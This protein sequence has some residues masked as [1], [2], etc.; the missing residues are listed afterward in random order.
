MKLP[1]GDRAVVEIEKLRDYSLDPVH[2]DGKHKARV[3]AAALGIGRSQ[4]E[5]LRDEVLRFAQTAECELGR[6]TDFGQRYVMQTALSYRNRTTR[7]RVVWNIRPDE[8]FP[9]MITC[10][11]V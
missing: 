7:V 11:V 6:K 5:W 9:R 1:N 3:F 8:D 4:A 10:F 2:A